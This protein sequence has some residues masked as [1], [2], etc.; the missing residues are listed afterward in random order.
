MTFPSIPG[1]RIIRALSESRRAQVYL[2]E[3]T[4]LQR[5]IAL[6]VLSVDVSRDE[7]S[8]QRVIA[9]GKA[10]ARLT[11]PNLLGVFDIGEH[12][13][14]H[15]IATEHVGGGSL[16]DRMEK[17]A[18]GAD[19]ALAVA[20]D[21]CSGL[22]FLHSQGFL[23]RD[24]KPTNVLFREDG[25]AVL[26]EAGVSRSAGS[27]GTN[28]PEAEVAFGSPHYMSPERA[29]AMPS[30]G[31]SDLY[32]VGVVLWEMLTGSPPFDDD[33]PFAVAVKH[34]S[35][36]IPM[37]PGALV[38]MQPLLQRLLAKTPAE[39]FAS[40]TEA[41]TAL[42]QVLASRGTVLGTAMQASVTVP[43]GMPLPQHPLSHNPDTAAFSPIDIPTAAPGVPTAIV[44]PVP[45][46]PKPAKAVPRPPVPNA[47]GILQ[48]PVPPGGAPP[49]PN[50]TVVS[51]RPL[52]AAAPQAPANPGPAR[53]PVPAATQVSPRP[54]VQQPG[55]APEPQFTAPVVPGSAPF[56]ASGLPMQVAAPQQGQ[57]IPKRST[58]AGWLIWLGVLGLLCAAAGAFWM[59]RKGQEQPMQTPRV[60]A[61]QTGASEQTPSNESE[62]ISEFIRKA[63]LRESSGDLVNPLDD[64]AAY[65]YQEALKLDPSDSRAQVGLEGVAANVEEQ[66]EQAIAEGRG[67]RASALIDN[68]LKFFPE[69]AKIKTLSQ[70][71]QR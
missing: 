51:P 27:V 8:R 67:S 70:K 21:L 4:S 6:K 65:F 2:A 42:D 1:Y 35:A 69:R 50:A 61:N 29:Q 30:D 60:N 32:S 44:E 25:M 55:P 68:A 45:E 14:L 36:P 48:R 33:D 66:I 11:H 24:I 54:M 38:S 57:A 16:R 13:G 47:T 49:V 18:L 62:Q 59:Y 71:L 10:A 46:K 9:E 63:N 19:Q 43:G 5:T 26:G 56:A 12:E 40:A 53:P 3:Q 7:G 64:C 39:R 28:T 20:R 34:I 37:L 31:R 17:G 22:A 41:V 23:H 52:P 15:Y 58:A